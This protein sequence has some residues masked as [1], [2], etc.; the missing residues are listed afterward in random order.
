[1]IELAILLSLTPIVLF[2][3]HRA[4]VRLHYVLTALP[5]IAIFVGASITIFKH[6]LWQIT[7]S[8]L[9]LIL[10]TIWSYQ[11]LSSLAIVNE[12]TAPQ[13]MNEPLK[14]ARDVAYSL[15]DDGR[16]VVMH[17][18][19]PNYYQR[20]EPAIWKVLLWNRPHRITNG[21]SLLLLPDE[22]AYLMTEHDGIHAWQEMRDT[23]I[24]DERL[25]QYNP[26]QG[27]QP[28]FMQPYDGV[29][30]PPQTIMLDEPVTFDSGLQLLGWYSRHVDGQVRVSMLYQAVS[31]PPND[32]SL[33]QFT[34]LRYAAEVEADISGEPA[35]IDD[36]ELTL[37]WQQG[38]K[39][40]AIAAFTPIEDS[41]TFFV[42][43][44]HY[45]LSTGQRYQHSN[46]ADYL[47]FG[48]FDWT[49]NES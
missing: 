17:T 3:Y 44:G 30:L 41:G 24:M 27:A 18:Q 5:A 40:I 31:N 32:L 9:M 34:H 37:S 23:G 6:R 47:R 4:P 33:R 8:A 49:R 7:I 39:M 2:T 1:V 43:I 29:T 48:A 15:P 28:Y 16:V 38:D 20:G 45:S 35:Y 14:A 10:A 42:D 22:P 12:Q 25:I 13:G 46:G 21:W 26:M 36:I 19:S 11:V